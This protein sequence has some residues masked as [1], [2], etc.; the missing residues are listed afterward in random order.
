[1]IVARV[2]LRHAVDRSEAEALATS[3]TCGGA[4]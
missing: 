3:V 4:D 1:L 2:M